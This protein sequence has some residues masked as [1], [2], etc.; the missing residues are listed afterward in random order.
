[1][2]EYPESEKVHAIRDKSQVVGEFIDWLEEKGYSICEYRETMF[3]SSKELMPVPKSIEQWLMEF[4]E[5]DRQKYEK[6][7]EQ[8][9][10]ELANKVG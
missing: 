1:M 6:E 7:K 3:R 8:M 9:A 2:S 5:I 4:F 10:M